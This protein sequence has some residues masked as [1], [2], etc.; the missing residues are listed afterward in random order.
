MSG[1]KIFDSIQELVLVVDERWNLFYANPAASM[2]F[3]VSGRRLSSGKPLSQFIEFQP[4][5]L[6][7]EDLKTITESSQY[8]ELNF[9]TPNGKNGTT[10]VSI[11]K[12]ELVEP[13]AEGGRWII[14]FRDVSL[15][16]VL[17]KKYRG[18]LEQKESVIEDLKKAQNQLEEYS[19]NLEV[20][21]HER[22]LQ[23]REANL[24]MQ[25]ILDSLGQGILVFDSDGRILPFFSKVCESIFGMVP[26]GLLLEEILRLES[27][28]FEDSVKWR[29][30]MFD[31]LLPFEDIVGL[32]IKHFRSLK[33]RQIELTY[34]PMRTDSGALKNVVMVATDKTEEFHAKQEAERE[35]NFARMVTQI[36]RNKGQFRVFVRESRTIFEE[37]KAVVKKVLDNNQVTE[38]FWDEISRALHTFK[39]G[40][41]SFALYDLAHITHRAEDFLNSVKEDPTPE[42]LRRF[43]VLFYQISS[44]FE[45]FLRSQ[46]DVL[47][48]EAQLE[49]RS[50]ELSL[51]VLKAWYE[52]IDR[53]P[54]LD[55]LATEIRENYIL[56]P[57]AKS[58]A[59]L[60]FALQD[61]A[62][63]LGKEVRPL[64]LIGGDLR[65][66]PEHFED[67]FGNMIHIF[68]NAVDHGL[69]RPE[70]REARGKES[71]GCITVEFER[72][73]IGNHY[74]RPS[75]V[76][77]VS[78][79]GRGIDPDRLKE[80]LIEKD[81]WENWREKSADEL[82]QVIFENDFSTAQSVSN[83]SGRGVGL[84]ALKE[85]IEKKGGSLH[86][87]SKVGEGSVFHLLIPDAELVVRKKAA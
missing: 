78:D 33:D 51:R 48:G 22:T 79:D 52:R 37:A 62:S 3:E 34:S 55:S 56:E 39:G 81:L 24:L 57:I 47:G 76:I 70:E 69:E 64:R 10:Q 59:H 50:L 25:A 66:L 8:R 29:A 80:K 36:M 87:T 21:V 82:L 28:D 74:D 38:S 20:M 67:V 9:T 30:V 19:K 35:R 63:S 7:L 75:I 46:S 31:D 49:D 12:D 53:E 32:G 72:F 16:K 40:A 60:D 84:A 15:E 23:L 4:S 13:N 17:Q 54:R 6:E 44:S 5:L 85:A 27:K 41:G 71:A 26:T 45:G 42:N 14:Y 77:K 83:V 2:V 65:I 11:Q 68:R 43:A 58:F 1:Y 86:V 61:L 18:E 73:Q